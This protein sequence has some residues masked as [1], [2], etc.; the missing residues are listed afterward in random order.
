MSAHARYTCW[1]HGIYDHPLCIIRDRELL[2][3]MATV[4][5][6]GS[7]STIK[8]STML[9]MLLLFLNYKGK[10]KNTSLYFTKFKSFFIGMWKSCYRGC[11]RKQINGVSGIKHLFVHHLCIFSAYSMVFHWFMNSHLLLCIIKWGMGIL[12]LF[13]FC[14]C[15]FSF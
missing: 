6:K 2:A 14:F 3:V 8:Q 7:A 10:E 13:L 15:F 5:S 12:G 9:T 11:D 1:N 4:I